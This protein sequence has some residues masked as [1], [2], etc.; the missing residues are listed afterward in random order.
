MKTFNISGIGPKLIGAIIVSLLISSP[1]S[2]YLFSLIDQYVARNFAVYVNTL[3][4][5]IVTTTIILIF[6]RFILIRPL[7]RLQSA[8]RQAS[9]G[10]LSVTIQNA[11]KDEIGQLSMAF[12]EMMKDLRHLILK[13]NQTVGEVTGSSNQLNS[14]AEENSKAIEQITYAI[15][16]VN[17]GAEEQVK[18]ANELVDTAR[19]VSAQMRESSLTIDKVSKFAVST[20]EKAI[21]GN[22][23]VVDTINQMNEIHHTVGSTSKVIST[24]E[25]KSKTIGEIV[26]LITGIADQTNLLALNA[27]IEAAR[28]GEHG[29]GFAI[30]AQEVRKLAEQSTG[31]GENIK[32][33]IQDI[34]TE[35]HQAV[36]LME[37]GKEVVKKGIDKVNL[38]G[39]GFTGILKDIQLMKEQTNEMNVIID[40]VNQ[41]SINMTGKIE[42]VA[43]IAEQASSSIQTISASAE[44]QNASMEEISSS[45]SLLNNLAQDLSGELQQF[46]VN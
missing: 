2:A 28:A 30:V 40:Q 31:A 14:V 21:E 37:E 3:V 46:K 26:G 15:Q 13:T 12:D 16:D 32:K 19:G 34:Q 1:I 11:S 22:K 39:N 5:L 43:V 10:D 20:N 29:R 24:L 36:K 7:N 45:V 4:T 27:T 23:L 6:V 38:T 25:E 42:D 35:T 8:I 41:Q 17:T 9:K 33:I 44:E 18:R